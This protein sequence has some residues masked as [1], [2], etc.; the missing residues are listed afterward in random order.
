MKITAD[1]N[2][3]VRAIIDDDAIQSPRATAELANAEQVIIPDLVLCELVWVLTSGYSKSREQ[4]MTVVTRLASSL[5]VRLNTQSVKTG[6]AFLAQGGD[7]ADGVIASEGSGFGAN[8][9][10]SFDRKAVAL[11]KNSG[12]AARMP[13]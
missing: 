1:T 10:V 2:L 7:F 11:A 3:L 12:I 8:E 5:N 9:F 4:I 13:R 6:L